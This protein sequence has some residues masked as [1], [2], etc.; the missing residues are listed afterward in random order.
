MSHL[1]ALGMLVLYV[2]YVRVLGSISLE[3][4]NILVTAGF[5]ESFLGRAGRGFGENVI[6]PTLQKPKKDRRRESG[7]V[8][9]EKRALMLVVGAFDFLDDPHVLYFRVGVLSFLVFFVFLD[10]VPDV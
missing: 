8:P 5:Q 2:C 9:F 7:M 3:P 10:H 4:V 6:K 1:K